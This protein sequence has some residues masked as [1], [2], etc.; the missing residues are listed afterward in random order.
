MGSWG[1]SGS[2]ISLHPNH[3]A[4]RRVQG[5]EP[6]S[7]MEVPPGC[8]RSPRAWCPPSGGMVWLAC[9]IRSWPVAR[10][11][12]DVILGCGVSASVQQ[13][14]GAWPLSSVRVSLA[15][16]AHVCTAGPDSRPGW[17]PVK[18]VPVPQGAQLQAES[19]TGWYFTLERAQGPSPQLGW[20][21]SFGCPGESPGAWTPAPGVGLWSSELP[22]AQ[23]G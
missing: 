9:V 4:E 10:A 16:L 13:G 5:C 22:G 14:A 12:S 23:P 18:A 6:R 7:M 21:S 11:G 17:W 15:F 3:Q 20:G 19:G 2:R 1:I 8:T